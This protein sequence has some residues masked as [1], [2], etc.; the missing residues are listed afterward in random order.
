MWEMGGALSCAIGSLGF[1]NDELV[2]WM[3]N[4]F[5]LVQLDD[6]YCGTS[7]IMTHKRNPTAAE[8]IQHLR[9]HITG[10]VPTSY[11]PAVLAE[12]GKDIAVSFRL[13]A[14]MVETL[15]VDRT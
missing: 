2:L 11:T 8:Q 5:R 10:R 9:D 14:G 3:G 15:K 4:E 12:A 7:S 1:L 6:R 13:S